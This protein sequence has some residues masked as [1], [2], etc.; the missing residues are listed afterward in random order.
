MQCIADRHRFYAGPDP[1]FHFDADPDPEPD[2]HPDPDSSW[3]I[4]IIYFIHSNARLHS[5][6][7]LIRRHNFQSFWTEGILK[8]SGKNKV[9]F[10]FSYT[11]LDPAK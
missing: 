2:P 4:R 3:K 8:F 6:I 1:T 9:I 5:F 11:D 10:T 7:F